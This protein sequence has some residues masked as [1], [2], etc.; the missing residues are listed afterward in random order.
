MRPMTQAKQQE[1]L[2]MH[3]PYRLSAIDL[4]AEVVD[5]IRTSGPLHPTTVMFGT[6]KTVRFKN[7][8]PVTNA[9]VEHGFMS[10]RVMLEFLGVGLDPNQ[11]SLAEYRKHRRDSVTL[12]DFGRPLLTVTDVESQLANDRVLLEGIVRTIRAGHKGGAHLTRGGDSLPLEMLAA[13]CRGTRILV[14]H[15]LY[16]ALNHAVPPSGSPLRHDRAT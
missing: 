1:F 12:E 15:F 11:T 6:V 13:G 5:L 4:C 3:I 16:R 14:D 2:G 9:F 7:V 8:R 10:C